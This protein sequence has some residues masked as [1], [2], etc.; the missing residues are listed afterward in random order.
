MKVEA[1]EDFIQG[2]QGQCNILLSERNIEMLQQ[3]GAVYKGLYFGGGIEIKVEPNE[4]H[5]SAEIE[6]AHVAYTD[7]LMENGL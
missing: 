6:A 1:S 7:K 2:K 5:Y 4:V 3:Y